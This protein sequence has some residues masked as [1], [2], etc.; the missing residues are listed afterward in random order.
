MSVIGTVPYALPTID[1]N[2]ETVLGHRLHSQTIVFLHRYPESRPHAETNVSKPHYRGSPGPSTPI[3]D[4]V[5][6][7]PPNAGFLG[8]VTEGDSHRL[9]RNAPL[10]TSPGECYS[11]D[12]ICSANDWPQ[13][14]NGTASPPTLPKRTLDR[15]RM[16]IVHRLSGEL[17]L[18]P[19]PSF[20]RSCGSVLVPPLF[21]PSQRL[22]ASDR[23]IRRQ[24]LRARA[25]LLVSPAVG[26]R[27]FS[28]PASLSA[29]IRLN[30]V[31]TL[32]PRCSM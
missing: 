9:L 26:I 10:D 16:Q 8:N 29:A 17:S 23:S 2:F 11:H 12:P 22:S 3:Q 25:I 4:F 7:R 31:A 32:R 24:L 14:R 6:P 1:H 19:T 18:L 20:A 13:F 30:S 15:S 21:Q 5:Q 27:T 28:K